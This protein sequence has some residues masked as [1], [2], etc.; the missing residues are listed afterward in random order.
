M[1]VS[2]TRQIAELQQSIDAAGTKFEARLKA[3][4]TAMSVAT[5]SIEV[6]ANI[7]LHHQLRAK[8]S[9]TGFPR[10]SLVA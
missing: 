3:A 4:N 9:I 5:K 7:S 1:A 8:R 2:R 10:P 6:I